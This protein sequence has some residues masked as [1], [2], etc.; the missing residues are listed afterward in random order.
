M[1]ATLAGIRLASNNISFKLSPQEDATP[2]LAAAGFINSLA[3]GI[4]PLIGGLFVD[5]FSKRELTLTLQWMSPNAEF[6]LNTFN[7]HHWDFFFFIAFVI[8][9]Y[10]LHR[11][12]KVEEEGKMTKREQLLALIGEIRK[13]MRNLSSLAGLRPMIKFPVLFKTRKKS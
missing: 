8:G 12:T 7:L 5:F 2:Y 11:L 3:A 9:L 4:A 10:S 13:E 1:G 6:A